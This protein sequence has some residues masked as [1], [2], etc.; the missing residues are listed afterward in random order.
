M[1]PWKHRQAACAAADQ[2]AAAGH[3]ITSRW[4]RGHDD[5]TDPVRLRQEAEHDWDD[6]HIADVAVLLNIEPS[7]GKAVEQGIALANNKADHCG[8]RA[9]QCVPPLAPVSVG[10]NPR[11]GNKSP[12]ES[13]GMLKWMTGEV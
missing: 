7:E 13:V 5:T 2:I 12:V 11:N 3:I 8:G 10:A 6:V 9:Q 1:A 4:L